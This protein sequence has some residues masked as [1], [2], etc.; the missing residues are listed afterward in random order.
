VVEDVSAVRRSNDQVGGTSPSS[1]FPAAMAREVAPGGLEVDPARR[2]A[3]LGAK[4]EEGGQ[5]D[6]QGGHTTLTLG[7]ENASWRPRRAQA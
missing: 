6:P 4:E 1:V 3:R 7:L 5:R 2:R